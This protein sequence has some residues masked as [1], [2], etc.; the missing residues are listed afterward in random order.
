ML[1]S[2]LI[3]RVYQAVAEPAAWTGV[4]RDICRAFRAHSGTL[5]F[6]ENQN[7]L[8][9]IW[10][11]AGVFEDASVVGAYLKHYRSLDIAVP[12]FAGHQTGRFAT[13]ST[14][15]S[16]A[17]LERSEFYNDFF[18]KL[19]L[20]DALGGNILRDARGTALFSVQREAG[21]PA[22]SA[23]DVREMESLG[24][25]LRRALELHRVFAPHRRAAN[26]LADVLEKVTAGVV[27]LDEAGR[28]WYVNAV[29]REIFARA[30]GLA[31]SPTG[32]LLALD[33]SAGDRIASLV[34]AVL[35]RGR[36]HPGGRTAVSRRD[37][38]APYGVLVSPT[39]V[40]A[41]AFFEPSGGSGATI[42]ISDPDRMRP[43]GLA[44]AMAPYGLTGAE[45]GLLTALVAG[46]SVGEYCDRHRLSINTGKFH[47]RSLFAK[48]DTHRQTELVRMALTAL[49]DF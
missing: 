22:F 9:S 11:S 36:R 21:S 18:L 49:R 40:E 25:H 45:L 5:A 28:P 35:T 3:D 8:S 4:V 6:S 39:S 1:D 37:G 33:R 19:G 24:Q 38:K 27:L 7:E 42:L 20:V 12:A 16:P 17:E 15:F 43:G 29:A 47:L 13:T 32:A 14:L 31:L 10:A 44:A 34:G 41:T 26:A 2:S 23:D 46:Q 48:T 30:D